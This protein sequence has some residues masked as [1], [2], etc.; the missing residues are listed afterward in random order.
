MPMMA[1]HRYCNPSI[2]LTV[3]CCATDA[4]P[5][6]RPSIIHCLLYEE[7]VKRAVVQVLHLGQFQAVLQVQVGVPEIEFPWKHQHE[8]TQTYN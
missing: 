3:D 2:R 7:I 4:G 1:G 5:L 8:K 6:G